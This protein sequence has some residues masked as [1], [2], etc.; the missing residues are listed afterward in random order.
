MNFS[1]PIDSKTAHRFKKQRGMTLIEVL[2]TFL[3]TSVGIMGL[4][5]LQATS[6]K[7]S[8]D[9]SKRSQG[10]WLTEELISRMRVNEAGLITGYTTAATSATLCDD[11][12]AK[13]CS[14]S[15]NVVG[16]T[17][18]TAAAD[19]SANEMATYDVWEV[20]CGHNYGYGVTSN[21]TDA[22]DI[23]TRD[24]SC[25][26]TPCTATSNFTVR[27]RWT[28]KSVFDASEQ[29]A[30]YNEEATQTISVTFRP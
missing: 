11:A 29:S 4:A 24:I 8:M 2:V 17:I 15:K 13:M 14:D 19:C 1:L 27:L 25:A 22:M 6:I 5:A 18:A 7:G 26:P 30:T 16:N 12:P 21:S 23:I 28:A 10:V 9:T 20:F 3:V